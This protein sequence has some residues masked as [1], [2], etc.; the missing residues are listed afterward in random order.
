M[1]TK[2]LVLNASQAGNS[3]GF[4]FDV[5]LST[6]IMAGGK[7]ES[8]API[9]AGPLSLNMRGI[10]TSPTGGA[11]VPTKPTIKQIMGCPLQ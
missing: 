1:A 11:K 10:R 2:E 3:S 7:L 5:S 9:P 6:A 8:Q 4:I